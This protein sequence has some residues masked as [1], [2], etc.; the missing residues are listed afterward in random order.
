MHQSTY[1]LFDGDCKQAMELYHSVLGGELV[2]TTIGES[3][4]KDVFPSTMYTK[5]V[6]ARLK[7]EVVDLSASDWLR[8]S[9]KRIQGNAVCIYLSGGSPFATK[10]IFRQLSEGADAIE[11]LS[12]QSF[13]LYGALTD[14]FGIRWMFHAKN[15]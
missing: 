5:V 14:K 15:E 3:P 11:A 10:E 2:L 1:L 13:G 8:P 6:N 7:G 4:M 12:E 9:Q